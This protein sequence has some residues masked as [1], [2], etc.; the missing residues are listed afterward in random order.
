MFTEW[1]RSNGYT[2]HN[3]VT[4]PG[5]TTRNNG[6]RIRRNA[7]FDKLFTIAITVTQK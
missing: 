5:K 1:L 4:Y 7:L 3:I 6:F 2:R